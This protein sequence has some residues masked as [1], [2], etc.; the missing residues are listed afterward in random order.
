MSTSP[1]DLV[2]LVDL[3]ARLR[4]P[5]GCPW[6]RRQ[7]LSTV[8][9]YLI[10]EAHE[11]AAA[12][13]GGN[14]REIAGELGD[15]LFQV[16]FVTRLGEES[17]ELDV[18]GVVDGIVDKMVERHPHVFGP[19]EERLGSAEEVEAAWERRK[20]EVAGGAGEAAGTPAPSLLA[21]VPRSL[22]TL[23]AAYRM[24]QKAAGVGFDWPD[25]T[26]VLE[27]LDEETAELRRALELPAGERR[28]A[29]IEAE[30][31]DILFTVANL[32]R[33]L[34]VDPDAA[35]AR[36]NAKFRRRFGHVER[37]MAED[38]PPLGEAS[39][40]EMDRLWEEAKGGEVDGS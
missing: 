5:D 11:A 16:A 6:D 10:E 25:V 40:G 36:T 23:V 8:R 3:V 24:T 15:L 39:L 9:A 19:A 38:G 37:R 14:W 1:T 20:L 4:A 21:G 33:K 29:E 12:V 18:A 32:A 28:A 26:D 7:T 30:V 27:K 22:P 17:G 31:G 35:L 2:R 34:G 13:S